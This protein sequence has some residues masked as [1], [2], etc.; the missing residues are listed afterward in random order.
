[1]NLQAPVAAGLLPL[2][3]TPVFAGR[4]S[5]KH[6]FNLGIYHHVV[7]IVTKGPGFYVGFQP[8]G[9]KFADNDGLDCSLHN[10]RVGHDQKALVGGSAS[11]INVGFALA[12]PQKKSVMAKINR[13]TAAV[14][15]LAPYINYAEAPYPVCIKQGATASTSSLLLPQFCCARYLVMPLISIMVA[16]TV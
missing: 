11:G 9:G 6:G 1:M 3:A 12:G 16:R 2:A 14:I 13:G 4:G 8:F 7:G 10:Q 5:L 15:P